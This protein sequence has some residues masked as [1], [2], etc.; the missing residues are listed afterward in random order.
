M[1]QLRL[2]S[3][4]AAALPNITVPPLQLLTTKLFALV[5]PIKSAF[6][7]LSKFIAPPPELI[8]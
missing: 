4:G 5:P 3:R 7:M 2:E 8:S 1:T 6:S